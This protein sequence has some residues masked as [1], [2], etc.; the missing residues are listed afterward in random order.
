MSRAVAQAVRAV[1]F[2]LLIAFAPA[3]AA[4]QADKPVSKAEV[5]QLIQTI[6]QPD[7]RERLVAQLKLLTKAEHD[8]EPAEDEGL[9]GLLTDQIGKAGD[10][11]TDAISGLADVGHAVDWARLQVTDPVHRALWAEVLGK[12]SILFLAGFAAERL[13]MLILRPLRRWLEGRQVESLWL[14]LPLDLAMWGLEVLPI[15]LFIFTAHGLRTLPSLSLVGDPL[16]ATKLINLAYVTTRL[17]LVSVGALLMPAA[18]AMRPL[19]LDDETASYLSIWSRRLTLTAVWGYFALQAL[20]LLGLPKSGYGIAMKGLGLMVAALL[21]ILVLQNRQAVADWIRRRGKP[22]GRMQGIKDRLADVWHVLACLYVGGAFGIWAL[23]VKGGFEFLMRAS[24]LTVLV[25]ALANGLAGFGADLVGRAFS[26]GDDL[27]TRLPHLEARANRYVAGLQMLVKL[28]VGLLAL[29]ALLQVWG[30]N[31]L[32]WFGSDVGRRLLGSL[33]TIATILLLALVV[34]ELVSAGIERYLAQTDAD[35]NQ[36]QRSARARTL[37]PL[38]RTVVMVLLLVMVSLMVLS[39]LGVNIAPLL[40]G[41]GVVGLAIGVGSQKLVQDVITG[42]FIL[43]EDT[44][45]VGDTVKIGDNSGTVEAL[46]IRTIRIRAGNG[47]LHTLP[48]SA[49]TTII[50]MSRDF[51]Y[52]TFDISVAYHEDVDRVMSA[53]RQVGEEMKA[54][55]AWTPLLPDLIEVFGVDKFDGEEVVIRGR[56]KTAPGK[57]WAVGREFN[58]RLKKLF[59]DLGVTMP[60]SGT[61]LVVDAASLKPTKG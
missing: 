7:A 18:A 16:Q 26:I 39:E 42:A 9:L 10:E 59:D 8:A 13:L 33:I 44:I 22:G 60:T 19:P 43:F 34:W 15:A 2:V 47:Q 40:A 58:H 31:A 53:I 11:L 48:F 52:H 55:E 45:A 30:I 38:L 17:T 4:E 49:V 3:H 56:Q 35:G 20:K 23:Q 25:L 51:G 6:E 24:A 54:D 14:R 27:R 21:V 12:F 36:V 46:T 28:V 29:V 1:A 50:N 41:A 37:L 32:G 61:T 57:Q 5:D